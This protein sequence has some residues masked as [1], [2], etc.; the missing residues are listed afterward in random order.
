M[1]NFYTNKQHWRFTYNIK[2]AAKQHTNKQQQKNGK[3][4]QQ[5]KQQQQRQALYNKSKENTQSKEY[6]MPKKSFNKLCRMGFLFKIKKNLIEIFME[7][8]E[9]KRNRGKNCKRCRII[10]FGIRSLFVWCTNM[11][12]K[13]NNSLANI[14]FQFN[15]RKL[16]EEKIEPFK[17]SCH[18][19]MLSFLAW[20]CHKKSKEFI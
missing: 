7:S 20:F 18:L 8:R 1:A 16:N 2:L 14:Y 3:T 17:F 19:S 10:M 5:Q 13:K 12:P 9:R 4:K 6:A 11:K 15:F